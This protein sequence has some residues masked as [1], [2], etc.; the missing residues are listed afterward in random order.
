MMDTQGM[1][2]HRLSDMASL[3][4]DPKDTEHNMSQ[5]GSDLSSENEYLNII[6]KPPFPTVSIDQVS[7]TIN[8]CRQATPS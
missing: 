6:R 8:L 2:Q 1:Y 7:L 3:L 5:R 4:K